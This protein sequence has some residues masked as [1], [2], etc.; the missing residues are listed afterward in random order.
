MSHPLVGFTYRTE[1]HAE[2]LAHRDHFEVLEVI[3]DQLMG[4]DPEMSGPILQDL[5]EFPLVLHSLDLSL[6]SAHPC[7]AE[8]LQSLAGLAA[9]IRPLWCSDH[10]C[11][12][13]SRELELGQLTPL[14]FTEEACQAVCRNLA[15]VRQHLPGYQFLIENITNYIHYP[16]NDFSETDFIRRIL[17][18]SGAKLL[19]DVNNVFVNSVNYGFDPYRFIDRLEPGSAVQIHIAGHRPDEAG[20]MLDS[21]DTRVSDEVWRLLEH[22]LAQ[23]PIQAVT[24]E[25]DCDF[26]SMDVLIEELSIA[27]GI[28]RSART[29][30]C[31]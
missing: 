31:R 3:A 21:H 15:L 9:K 19:L 17:S 14:P 4:A 16:Q 8:Y 13:Q 23:M 22:T 7:R 11:F 5:S 28:A 25:W 26:P 30:V 6:G 27:R 20:G 29:L 12:T 1:L 24:L 2:I 18:L 10:L